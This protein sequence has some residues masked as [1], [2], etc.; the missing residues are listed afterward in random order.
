MRRPS[1]FTATGRRQS[2]GIRGKWRAL[3]GLPAEGTG[4]A[5]GD[6]S[7]SPSILKPLHDRIVDPDMGAIFNQDR[8]LALYGLRDRR[9]GN[10]RTMARL[11]QAASAL[12]RRA[13]CSPSGRLLLALGATIWADLDVLGLAR[14]IATERKRSSIIFRP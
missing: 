6:E 14:M 11:D 4:Q 8:G 9:F 13:H 3:S 10:G 12:G 2:D 5:T 1:F 7:P